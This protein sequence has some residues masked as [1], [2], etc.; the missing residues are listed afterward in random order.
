MTKR[1][2]D[3][4]IK[5]GIKYLLCMTLVAACVS[6][7]GCNSE[8]GTEPSEN[9]NSLKF[10]V[11]VSSN[12]GVAAIK[13]TSLKKGWKAGDKIV[14]SID[15]D[16][17]NICNL[18]FLGGSN[19]RVSKYNDNT[20]FGKESGTLSAIYSDHL[21]YSPSGTTV[22]GDI[23]YTKKGNYKR[24][25]NVVE[26]NLNMDTRPVSRIVVTGI[27]KTFWIDNIEEYS[28]VG[29]LSVMNFTTSSTE[30]KSNN[31]EVYGDTVVFYGR[32]QSDASSNTEIILKSTGGALCK[33]TFPGKTLKAGESILV[34][35][36]MSEKDYLWTTRNIPVIGITSVR[37]IT[38]SEGQSIDCKSIYTLAPQPN[39]HPQKKLR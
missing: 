24:H 18:E 7:T 19:W 35:G 38:L 37:N 9:F 21:F 33:R 20:N 11:N 3:A 28:K 34:E 16:D 26:I 39:F 10:V 22:G 27:D 23:L 12:D 1:T 4:L 17:S 30:H 29:N 6:L 5:M 8:E 31:R 13:G 2:G 15:N 14:V 36:P 25:D 32:L